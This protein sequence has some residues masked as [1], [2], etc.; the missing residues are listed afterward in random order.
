MRGPLIA[1]AS[2]I[3]AVF[4]AVSIA[5]AQQQVEGTVVSTKMTACDMKPGGCEG[6]MT[7]DTKGATPGPVTIKIQKGTVIKHGD[8]YLF[9]PGTKGRVVAV[10]YVE[11]KGEKVAKSVEAK[12]GKP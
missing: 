9:L 2:G 8:G 10:T 5:H 11:D 7:L 12:S 4:A 6:T 1:V 3:F